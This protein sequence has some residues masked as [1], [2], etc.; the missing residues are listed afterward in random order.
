MPIV[1]IQ[2]IPIESSTIR[3]A[4]YSQIIG[5]DECRFWGIARGTDTTRCRTIWTLPQR[6]NVAKYLAEAQFE[7]EKVVGFPVGQ[8]WFA[9]LK[10]AYI[11]P[12]ETEQC[13]LIEGG[14]AKTDIIQA[15]AAVSHA[16]DPAV[17]GP[18]AGLTF[19]DV[20]EV[21]V[22]HPGSTVEI[23]P[24]E[25]TIV[26]G[27]LTIKIPRCRMVKELYCDNP[28]AGLGYSDMA[29]FEATVDI[30]RIYNDPS[31]Q[32]VFYN[33][34]T[35]SQICQTCG[36]TD[37]TQTGCLYVADPEIGKAEVYP[38]N[39][40]SGAWHKVSLTCCK[41][42]RFMRLY[43]RAGLDLN[44]DIED[45]IVRLAH[46]KMPADPCG[47]DP[48]RELWTRDRTVPEVL[49]AERLNCDFGTSDGAW[50]AW[51]QALALKIYRGGG[52]L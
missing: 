32:V 8:R 4:R 13:Y 2:T 41:N 22:Y 10:R 9:D 37:T 34:H 25:A 23:D 7:F 5:Y 35:C 48:A 28:A 51:R 26:A 27:S 16:T 14:I 38:A 49:T 52:I 24:S 42:Y 31:Q 33:N 3:L 47:C 45:A 39:Y 43:Y 11:C 6:L 30:K 29:K 40:S 21:H 50:F 18:I 17:I 46:S 44:F 36:C 12:V 15:A 20:N 1:P 19:T